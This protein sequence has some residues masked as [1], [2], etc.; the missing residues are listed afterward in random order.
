LASYLQ[1]PVRAETGQAAG[2]AEEELGFKRIQFVGSGNLKQIFGANSLTGIDRKR[3]VRGPNESGHPSVRQHPSV[4]HLLLW[5]GWSSVGR[6]TM[7]LLAGLGLLVLCGAGTTGCTVTA[8][9]W[10]LCEYIDGEVLG[11]RLTSQGGTDVFIR[12]R[13]DDVRA[14]HVPGDWR[15]DPVRLRRLD[16]ERTLV[17]RQELL[18]GERMEL[19]PQ[20]QKK[21]RFAA[22]F[23]LDFQAATRRDPQSLPDYEQPIDATSG[24]GSEPD[25]LA[26]VRFRNDERHH[27]YVL[28]GYDPEQER[29]VRLSE[30]FDLGPSKCR[31]GL[32]LPLLPICLAVDVL[33][34][35]DAALTG[36]SFRP[37]PIGR[38]ACWSGLLHSDG[39]FPPIS[40][41]SLAPPLAPEFLPCDLPK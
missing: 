2:I 35:A 21:T 27:L 14:V 29:W 20:D 16:E 25:H 1:S 19:A 6:D 4:A 28:F 9:K 34:I 40:T 32:V 22:V 24:P 39:I 36:L 10:G 38:G 17:E 30:S 13:G 5:L 3:E 7:K 15:K 18:V 23:T 31:L 26:F 11:S 41:D 12:L 37:I 33:R 8:V